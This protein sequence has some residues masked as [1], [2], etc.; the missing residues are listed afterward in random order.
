MR[1]DHLEDLEDA[2]PY[3]HKQEEEQE[4][5]SHAV[6]LAFFLD[7]ASWDLKTI[8]KHHRKQNIADLLNAMNLH[9]Q[10]VSLKRSKRWE[11]ISPTKKNRSSKS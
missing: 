11:Y 2:G 6:P 10:N 7:L 4:A 8:V 5:G 1:S 3:H 9:M